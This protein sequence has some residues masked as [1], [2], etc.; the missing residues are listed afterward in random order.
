MFTTLAAIAASLGLSLIVDEVN[1]L[2][3][4]KEKLSPEEIAAKVNRILDQIRAKSSKKYNDALDALQS[5]PSSEFYAGALK[6]KVYDIRRKARDKAIKQRDIASDVETSLNSIQ[7][8]S[9]NLQTA[10]DAYRLHRGQRDIDNIISD[11]KK[12]DQTLGD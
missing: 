10:T 6:E 4:D 5:V 3:V 9:F 11:L 1:R 7:Q 8:R 12:V 2:M